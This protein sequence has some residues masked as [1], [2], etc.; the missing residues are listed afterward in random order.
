M[1]Q[2][3]DNLSNFDERDLKDNEELSEKEETEDEDAQD[4]AQ[5]VQTQPIS[6][7]LF[8]SYLKWRQNFEVDTDPP[9]T[10]H[11]KGQTGFIDMQQSSQVIS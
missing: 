10:A 4:I 2:H 3:I 7:E 5:I 11:G 1:S 8:R 9:V 6:M